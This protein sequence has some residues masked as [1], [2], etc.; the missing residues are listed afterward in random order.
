MVEEKK[1]SSNGHWPMDDWGEGWGVEQEDGLGLVF[2]ELKPLQ[3]YLFQS[4]LI[5]FHLDLHKNNAQI[6]LLI[7]VFVQIFSFRYTVDIAVFDILL[8]MGGRLFAIWAIPI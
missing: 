5:N 1:R 7:A 8:K 3:R 2:K 6:I 4:V